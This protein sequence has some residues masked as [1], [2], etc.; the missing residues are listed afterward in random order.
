MTDRTLTILIPSFDG[1]C[2]VWPAFFHCFNK[3]WSDCPYPLK[4]VSNNLSYPMV[5]M[6]HTGKENIWSRRILRALQEI[7][8][9]YVLLLLEDYFI[10][11]KVD[12]AQIAQALDYLIDR[13][14]KYMRLTEIPK[15]KANS[16]EGNISPIF[17]NE[18]YGVNLQAAIWEKQFL[19]SALETS[20]G[21]AWEFEIDFLKKAAVAEVVPLVGCYVLRGEP[22]CLHN[23]ILKGKWFPKEIRF[24]KK[25]GFDVTKSDRARLSCFEIFRYH[26]LVFLKNHISYRFRKRLKKIAKKFGANFVSDI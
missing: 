14:G 7:D 26:S 13:K 17:A 16:S 19:L 9:P 22:L 11:K 12:T 20:A 3:N 8:T 6:I 21:N 18:E 10:G 2:D 5:D 25:Q 23:G 4:L 15:S 1:Y 24:L